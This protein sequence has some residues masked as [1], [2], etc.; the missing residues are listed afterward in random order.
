MIAEPT[1]LTAATAK[2]EPRVMSRPN[3][4]NVPSDPP[5]KTRAMLFQLM[6]ML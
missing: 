4:N 6:V 3:L 1:M 5:A 2:N